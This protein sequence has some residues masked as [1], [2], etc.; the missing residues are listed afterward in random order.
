MR[1]RLVTTRRFERDLRR[2]KRRNKDLEKLW[3]VVERLLNGEPLGPRYRRHAL[4]GNWASF[5]EC[6]LEPDWLMIWRETESDL[7]LVRT[8]SHSDLFG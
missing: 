4:S 5:L 8:G 6:H 1:R 2:A 3:P 7:V